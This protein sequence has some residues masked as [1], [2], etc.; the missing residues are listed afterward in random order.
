MIESK[1]KQNWMRRLLDTL[2]KTY[3]HD[4]YLMARYGAEGE[5]QNQ[6]YAERLTCLRRQLENDEDSGDES[7]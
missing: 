5:K 7:L 2:Q 3:A 1:S 6:Q 4:A